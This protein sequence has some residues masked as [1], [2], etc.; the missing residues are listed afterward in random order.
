MI[1]GKWPVL[2]S[3]HFVANYIYSNKHFLHINS[4]LFSSV[5]EVSLSAFA[6]K[7]VSNIHQRKI[8]VG[9]TATSIIFRS[10]VSYN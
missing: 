3:L 4:R 1:N 6:I 10:I 2:S 8:A 5:V 9:I 7:A